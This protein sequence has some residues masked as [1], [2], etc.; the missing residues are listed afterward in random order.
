MIFL[1][2]NGEAVRNLNS[3]PLAFR[4]QLHNEHSFNDLC[5]LLTSIQI[6]STN[7][8]LATPKSK[9]SKAVFSKENKPYLHVPDR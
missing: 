2:S 5:N 9:I 7:S 6:K 4:F 8:K 3:I 1:L